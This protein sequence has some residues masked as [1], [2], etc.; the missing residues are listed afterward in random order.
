MMKN[1][2]KDTSKGST[3][4]RTSARLTLSISIAVLVL[5]ALAP[6]A[7]AIFTRARIASFGA[8][9]TSLST[10]NRPGELAYDQTADR[11][12]VY[13]GNLTEK[14]YAFNAP[15]LNPLGGLFPLT[16][17]DESR[18][19]LASD[20]TALSSAG[21]V[22][23]AAISTRKL[24][25]FKADGTPLGGPFPL[26]LP[27]AAVPAG[28]AVD[29]AGVVYVSL[30][31]SGPSEEIR[32][33]DSDGNLLGT[34]S[35]ASVGGPG[36]L[37]FDSNN[38]LFFTVIP[39]GG[40][41]VGV[42]KATAAS[43]YSAV[44]KTAWSP[45]FSGQSP[46]A[47][48]LDKSSHTLYVADVNK[49]SAYS[50]TSGAFLYDFADTVRSPR[51]LQGLLGLAVDEGTDTV[52]VSDNADG[53][54][55]AFA[56]AQ[57]FADASAK[58]TAATNITDTSAQTG[59]TIDDNGALLTN[60][61]LEISVDNGQSW[62]TVS[63]GKTAGGQSNVVVT[64]TATGL[65]PNTDYKFRVVTNKGAGAAT[66]VPSFSLP[67]KTVAPPPV[68]SDLGAIQVA[69]TS[70]RLLA[71][72]DPRNTD[73]GYVFEY[74]TTP[75]L[76]SSTAPLDVGSGTNPITVSQVISGLTKDID[77]YFRVS[78]TNLIGT[79]TSSSQTFHTRAVPF[80]S[81]NPGNCPNE[82]VREEQG[83]TFLPDCFAYEMV[84]PPDKNQGGV[85]PVEK[86]LAG[87]SADGQGAAFCVRN[88]FG[89]PPAQMSFACGTYV[90]T[91]GPDGWSTMTPSPPLCRYDLDSGR[92][93]PQQVVLP[94]QTYQRAA[95]IVPEAADCAT[96]PLD[97]AAPLPAANLYR[98]DMG[99]DP[100]HFDLLT[101]APGPTGFSDRAGSVAGGSADFSHVVYSS[102]ANQTP[103]S[104]TPEDQSFR[105]LYDWVEEGQG[106]CAS[107]GGC[108]HLLSVDP[109]GQPF[110]TA[111]SLPTFPVF[112]GPT[113]IASAVSVDGR[114]IYFQ[115]Q[116]PTGGNINP[117]GRCHSA[118]C[119]LYMREDDTATFPVSASECT[120]ECGVDSSPD[121]FAWATPAGDKALFL[122]C[123][124]LTDASAEARTCS[125]GFSPQAKDNM[126]LYRWEEDAAP[127]H[128][129][130]DL[131]LDEEPADGSQPQALGE[132]GA[133]TDAGAAPGSNA[134]PGNT[135]YFVAAGQLVS[136]APT[137]PALKLYRW[138]W[139][140]G[141][142]DLR[143]L[144]PYVSIY[145]YGTPKNPPDASMEFDPN[146]HN[147]HIRVAPDGR[148]LVV[149]TP[150]A[151][152]PAAD[153]D[154]DVDLYRWSEGEGWLCVSCQLPGAPSAGDADTTD[155]NLLPE[156]LNTDL[157]G[158]SAE[159]TI[160]D[161]GQRI[162]F[163]TP[164]ALV[165]QDVNG[166]AAC[167]LLPQV[168][169]QVESLYACEDVYEWHDGTVSLLSSGTGTQ[170]F[171]LMGATA[172]GKEV[173]FA[174]VQR[175]LGWDVDNSS[176]IYAVRADSGFSEPPAQPLICEGA[177]QCHGQGSA[178]P[179]V[180]GAGTAVF[181][182]P[183]NPTA[184]QPKAR[185]KHKKR[186]HKHKR[187]KHNRRA[188]R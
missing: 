78:A 66:E 25:G 119:D 130:V 5:L 110:E 116:A 75:A 63:A 21:N 90:S 19:A 22:Y 183:G 145:P 118:A 111:S 82:A 136:G 122:S 188:G 29:S 79:T 173:F 170:P 128:H 26:S 91:R 164:D 149:Q 99:T 108:L 18:V 147:F 178:A 106:G 43:G 157:L 137:T 107:V 89:E 169:G 131:S 186:H 85:G 42:Y 181:E 10:F 143:Y 23:A 41:E 11:L 86:L 139:N 100:L 142:P 176:D 68:V 187:A 31:T 135:V 7:M 102:Y 83:S 9:G 4:R 74:G 69:D 13:D 166:E 113:P 115:N 120:V 46:G 182:G 172:S 48:A 54:V 112:A 151:L 153:R 76:G 97:P 12:Y 162:F 17:P 84:S 3:P 57:S 55:Y 44:T 52:Y 71:T 30:A 133:S 80:P 160:S 171:T 65:L 20:N 114:R 180:P 6:N 125:N 2:A 33:Y 185:K 38:D 53:Q 175:L 36:R 184:T 150:L 156:L 141:S 62:K 45:E 123:A 95:V 67:L 40:G 101:T 24:Y 92:V 93:G 32:K 177:E 8:D 105:K 129:L 88:L 15:A 174:T 94:T 159:H 138:R 37:T 98:E 117:N 109:A 158:Y 154:S 87:F 148:Y 77:Y 1:H 47:I 27:A 14:I 165:P 72:I 144:G 163:E 152:D 39:L 124:K 28:V 121:S 126:K 155:P 56:P 60:W 146:S 34:I 73:T 96:S 61:R 16:V 127:G 168:T 49:V 64:G 140:E 179:N 70:A 134:G 161:D 81:A 35:T 51:L 104:P 167:P 58:P 103:D 132:L 50:A 59:A